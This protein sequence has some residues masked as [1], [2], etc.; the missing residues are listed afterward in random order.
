MSKIF[1]IYLLRDKLS[2]K[3]TLGKL[4]F[5]GVFFCYTCEDTVRPAGVK[6]QG[7]TAIPYGRHK[8]VA[9]HSPR[10]KKRMPE[11]ICP[12]FAGVRFHNGLH[13]NHTEGCV[14]TGKNRN[15][16]SIYG[17]CGDEV[18]KKILDAIDAGFEVF[19]TIR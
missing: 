14:L 12:G 10:F 16:V 4:S 8:V 1:E 5:G 3:R 18:N 13:E 6:V 15:A 2:E 9:N 11:I 19:I 7:Q 17:K